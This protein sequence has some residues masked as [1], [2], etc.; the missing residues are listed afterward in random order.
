M[1]FPSCWPY[2][3]MSAVD[4]PVPMH[5]SRFSPSPGSRTIWPTMRMMQT[6]S[7]HGVTITV[8]PGHRK[9]ACGMELHRRK[10]KRDD[11]LVRKPQAWSHQLSHSFP[12]IQEIN[13]PALVI[14]QGGNRVDAEDVIEGGQDVLRGVGLAARAFAAGVGGADD[15]AHAQAAAG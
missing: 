14:G 13:R 15:L 12:I 4:L 8:T 3:R 5:P 1:L 10:R 7:W 6:A 9:R 2:S 11:E